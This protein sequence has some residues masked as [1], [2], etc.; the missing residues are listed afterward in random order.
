MHLRKKEAIAVRETLVTPDKCSNITAKCSPETP[1]QCPLH[2]MCSVTV[3]AV[4]V[5]DLII[6]I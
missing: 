5:R 4:V 3:V 1:A 6:N 2:K